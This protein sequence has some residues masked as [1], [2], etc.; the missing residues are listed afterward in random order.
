MWRPLHDH[1]VVD[2]DPKEDS[3]GLILLPEKSKERSR[4]ATVL[5]VGPGRKLDDGRRVPLPDVSVGDRVL[6]DK[7]A[8][9]QLTANGQPVTVISYEDVQAIMPP[10][11]AAVGHC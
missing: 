10:E 7:W 8:G 3:L 4:L 6:I 1:L 11:T 9:H 5:A 2:R